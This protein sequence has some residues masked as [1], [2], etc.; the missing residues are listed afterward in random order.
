MKFFLLRW[1]MRISGA[2]ACNYVQIVQTKKMN[3]W[4][5]TLPGEDTGYKHYYTFRKR[6][7]MEGMTAGM[8]QEAY[9]INHGRIL[10]LQYM[11]AL[12]VKLLKENNKE[13]L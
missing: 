6:H 5:M 13:P 4:L 11:N 10:E 7:I 8:S 9:W 12:A 1:L 3:D 2:L